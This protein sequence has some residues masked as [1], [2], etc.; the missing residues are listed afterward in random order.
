MFFAL[1]LIIFFPVFTAANQDNTIGIT[2]S[3]ELDTVN[4]SDTKPIKTKTNNQEKKERKINPDGYC[5]KI[6]IDLMGGFVLG[7]RSGTD[8]K[9]EYENRNDYNTDKRSTLPSLY[10]KILIPVSPK[11]SWGLSAE[12][13]A[14]P[15]NFHI[16]SNIY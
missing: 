8:F 14:I 12:F 7:N 16:L 3:L 2:K 13:F 6:D 11:F 15:V 1:I 9:Y 5:R 4:Y 10:S